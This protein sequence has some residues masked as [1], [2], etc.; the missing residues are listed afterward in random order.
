MVQGT[1]GRELIGFVLCT[2]LLL[3]RAFYCVMLT[4]TYVMY[5]IA[6]ACYNHSALASVLG[7]MY[8]GQGSML[9]ILACYIHS[10]TD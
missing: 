4:M 2:R 3:E 6:Q 9:Y 8:I 10:P 1:G 7:T 5:D